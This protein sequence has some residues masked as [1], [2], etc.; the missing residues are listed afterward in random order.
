MLNIARSIF[1][2][3]DNAAILTIWCIFSEVNLHL[4]EIH[5]SQINHNNY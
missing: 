2:E 5:V 3:T 4:K 1:Y